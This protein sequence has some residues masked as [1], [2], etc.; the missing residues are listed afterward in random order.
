MDYPP[1]L[2]DLQNA[3]TQPN[4]NVT[5]QAGSSEEFIY[6]NQCASACPAGNTNPSD[7]ANTYNPATATYN[8]TLTYATS[9]NLAFRQAFA[10]LVNYT[11]AQDVVLQTAGIASQNLL[12][13]QAFGSFSSTN[14]QVWTNSLAGAKASLAHDSNLKFEPSSATFSTSSLNYSNTCTPSTT[15]AWVLASENGPTYTPV[16]PIIITRPD[17]PTWL[18][19]TL[20]IQ[21][22]ATDIGL[23]L[24][25][26]QIT[27]F[28]NVAPIV[29]DQYS[30][31]WQMYFGGVGF[32]APL[33]P[34]T[35]FYFGLTANPGWVSS[36]AFN[37]VHAYNATLESLLHQAFTTSSV[38][39]AENDISQADVIMSQQLFLLNMWW[40]NTAIPSLNCAPSPC[41]S[42][43]TYW[44]GYVNVPA[45]T[46]W[47]FA[48][49][50]YTLLDVHQVN[51]SNGAT[52][53]GGTF[54]IGLHE[55]PDDLNLLQARSVYDF[56]AIA[57]LYDAPVQVSPSNPTLGGLIPWM[58]VGLP[59]SS[60]FT[61]KTPHGYNVVNGTRIVFNFMDNITFTDN[62][63]MTAADYNFTLWYDNFNGAFLNTTAAPYNTAF[64]NGHCS[65]SCWAKYAGNEPADTFAGFPDLT[66]SVV[67][68]TY[69]MTAYLNGTGLSDYVLATDE[70]VLPM[71]LWSQVNATILNNDFSSVGGIQN[72]EVNGIPLL[73]GTGPFQFGSFTQNQNIKQYRNAG[74]FRSDIADWAVSHT[75]GGTTPLSLTLTQI[76]FNGAPTNIPTSASVKATVY[77]NGSPTSVSTSLSS[78]GGS[79][80]GTLNT[81]SL[82][83]GFYEIV[84]NGTYTDSS[85]LAHTALQ[86]WGLNVSHGK[87]VASSSTT[88]TTP[89][90]SSGSGLSLPVIGAIIVV[91][92]VIVIASVLFLRRRPGPTPT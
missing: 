36:A 75:S 17:H 22:M 26:R 14:I 76:A 11:Y 68:S 15:G 88:T 56:D 59:A 10:Q 24:G 1:A 20:N 3:A 70:S 62:V 48:T 92:A 38:T 16:N 63:P 32:G 65:A 46:D 58:T 12:L 2:T 42:S 89:S 53:T 29:F 45:F 85:G 55:N 47:S 84:V 9:G 28:T 21:Q 43:S 73:V 54:T 5:T 27:G 4:L 30:A 8:E 23:C 83:D 64:D 33:N 69:T 34:I 91:I 39:T 82:A 77:Q 60:P 41:T 25:V 81:G 67:N 80:S 86:Y 72:Y 52:I 19:M 90:T 87:G 44:A 61:G 6:F 71:H 79:W 7:P 51:P 13:P 57:G 35:D 40:D 66:D 74:Y 31:N 78:S 50:E 18:A 49:G 37:T